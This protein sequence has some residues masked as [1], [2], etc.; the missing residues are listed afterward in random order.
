[1]NSGVSI[2]TVNIDINIIIPNIII[3]I[4]II[5][6]LLSLSLLLVVVEVRD[7]PINRTC[8][9]IA[10][11]TSDFDDRLQFYKIDYFEKKIV[12][13]NSLLMN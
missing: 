1:M 11:S 10:R 13:R 6:L 7:C 2:I 12:P 4:I 3:I 5:I 9:L 8:R